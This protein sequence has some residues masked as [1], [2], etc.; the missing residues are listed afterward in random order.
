MRW[1]EEDSYELH[2]RVRQKDNYKRGEFQCVM[3]KLEILDYRIHAD[4]LNGEQ[5]QFH[6]DCYKLHVCEGVLIK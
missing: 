4:V 5:V 2:G 6:T 3:C 1:E